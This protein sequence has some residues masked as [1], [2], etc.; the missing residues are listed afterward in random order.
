MKHLLAAGAALLLVGCD[1]HH[2]RSEHVELILNPS[3][4]GPATTFELRFDKPMAGPD[5]IGHAAEPSPLVIKPPLAGVFTWISP[6]SGVFLPSEPLA[7][8]HRYEFSLRSGLTGADGRPSSAVLRWRVK[9]PPLSVVYP[10]SGP[11]HADINSEQEV[12]LVFNAPVRAA[13]LVPYIEFRDEGGQRR[14]AEIWQGT[15]ED[16]PWDY[17]RLGLPPNLASNL[18]LAA[19]QQPLAVGK[20]WRLL[21]RT[22]LPAIENGLRLRGRAEIQLGDVR[23]FV[24]EQAIAH[25]FIEGGASI[26]LRFSKPVAPS[27]TNDWG[28]WIQVEPLASN[29]TAET[30][31]RCLKLQGDFHS[32][33]S[34]LL[35]ARTGLPAEQPFTLD[36]AAATN[37]IIPAIPARLYF[38][39]FSE[40][41][42]AVGRR[43]FPMLAVNVPSIHFRAK[44]LEPDVAVYALRGYDSYSS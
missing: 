16:M 43:Q 7:L 41:Q 17:Q 3:P 22:G 31:G 19:P 14:A 2:N 37:I 13:D 32:G 8:D 38:P 40:D 6:R 10:T 15:N 21:L 25:H 1:L 18:V 39:A 24:F 12:M 44:L 28:R 34:Y 33:T 26:V 4:P 29:I 23:P 11:I 42:Q 9:T 5:N 36:K 20:G 30:D 35:T 27:L